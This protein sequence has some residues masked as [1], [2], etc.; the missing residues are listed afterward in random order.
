MKKALLVLLTAALMLSCC[1]PASAAVELPADLTE[2]G[3][4]AFMN[5][6]LSSIIAIPDGVKTIGRRAF[7][8]SS[9][10]FF[11]LPSTLSSIA[12]DAFG[13]DTTFE[14][15]PDSYAQEWCRENGF[16]YD[17]MR[18]YISASAKTLSTGDSVRITTNFPYPG[19]VSA[20][21]WETSSDQMT[22]TTAA[23]GSGTAY[24]VQYADKAKLSSGSSLYVRCRAL[25][26][27]VLLQ[28][29][30]TIELSFLPDQLAFTE[31]ARALNADSVYLEWN[32]MGSGTK[33]YVQQVVH[34]RWKIIAEL[35]D[36]TGYTVYG[37]EKDTLYRFTVV[38][39]T[40]DAAGRETRHETEDGIDLRTAA[41]GAT[42]LK[43]TNCRSYGTALNVEWDTLDRAVY[44]VAIGPAGGTMAT[45]TT[46]A[47]GNSA[48]YY[49]FEPNTR[50]QVQVTARIP[51][52]SLASG[53]RVFESEISSVTT[54]AA[55][56]AVVLEEPVV[57]GESVSLRWSRLPSVSYVVH[58]VGPD[59]KDKEFDATTNTYLDVGGLARGKQY[60][61][62]VDSVLGTWSSRSE[63]VTV[64]IPT[65][66]SDVEYRAL[67]VGEV[68]FDGTQRAMRNYGDVE[69]IAK[70]LTSA[71]TP[72]GSAYACLRRQD[73]DKE[74]ILD[75]IRTAFREADDNDVSLFFIA[76]H[77]DI[78][79]IG[80]SAGS[81]ATVN[82][83]GITDA[84]RLEELA[85]ALSKVPGTVI[86]WLGSCGSGAAIYDENVPQNGDAALTAAAVAAFAAHDPT[87]VLDETLAADFTVG[88][89]NAFD[90][91][92]FRQPKFYVL[93]AA[94][95][96]EMSWGME[97]SRF[98]YFPKFICDGAT[99][100]A[101]TGLMPADANRDG[102]LTQHE[103]FS[104]IKVREE[105]SS[106][107]INQNVQEYPLNS[108]YVLFVS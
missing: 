28:A 83:A 10:G 29:G 21:R 53:W 8:G 68:S 90:R 17:L 70:L 67:L 54:G 36:T 98:N 87:I 5:A 105:D 59:G 73:L 91:G 75:E 92:E 62:R 77:G 65:A 22:W 78:D 74:D 4:E 12:P 85:D 33:Y 2:I 99:V 102:K 14:V 27:G 79:E 40:T 58:M 42:T 7:S 88:E 35:T 81:L 52:S 48:G 38:A 50:Y 11:Y 80:R 89:T 1:A 106:D 84:L 46:D 69:N 95:Y 31:D 24:T 39:I 34:G 41:A 72:T 56:P 47:T 43:I 18:V 16:D 26:H 25:V 13:K 6:T 94:R 61:F 93:T 107:F 108:D 66:K 100:D 63:T 60:S 97:G 44:D 20:F 96:H 57:T 15:L 55:D 103:L 45:Y 49:V 86:V 104:Y 9:A 82:E 64:R 19:R 76:T 23:E 101:K 51:D 3:D 71:K 30:N 32:D 37:L